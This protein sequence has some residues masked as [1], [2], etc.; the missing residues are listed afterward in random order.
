MPKRN[1]TVLGLMSGSSLDGLDVAY[2]TFQLADTEVFTIGNWK[3][4]IAETLTY[5][6]EWQKK[7]AQLIHTD[8]RTFAQT[9]VHFSRYSAEL[10]NQFL[11]KH[12]IE[13]DFIAAHGHTVFHFPEEH[14][15]TQIGEGAALAALTG[16]PVICDFRTFDVALGGQGAPIASIADKYLLSDY[17]FCL[18]LG[19]I[20]NITSN[21]NGKYIAFDITGANQVL[22]ELVSE[23]D[24]EYDDDGKLAAQGRVIPSILEQSNQLPFLAADYPKTLDNQWVQKKLIPLFKDTSINLKDRLRT[25]CEHTVQQIALS[26]EQIIKQEKLDQPIYR[27]LSTGGGGYNDFFMQLLYSKLEQLKVKVELPDEKVIG[28]KEAAMIALMGVMRVENVPNCMSSVTGAIHD[29]INGAIY[30]GWNKQI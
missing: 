8:A 2:C 14:F 15:T 6:P 12:A 1:Y 24:L 20:A 27:L 9:H 3:I 25:S 29:T 10:V 11:S 26:V 28:F 18:N 30:Q 19:G 22:N 16:Y 17:D 5:T 13:P 7:L 21:A 23:I 4:Q